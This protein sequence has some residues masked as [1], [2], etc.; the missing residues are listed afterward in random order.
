HLCAGGV[1]PPPAGLVSRA[2]A[3]P[4][5]PVRRG[6]R[7]TG[8]RRQAGVPPRHRDAAARVPRATPAQ[9]GGSLAPRAGPALAAPM[10]ATSY[11]RHPDVLWRRSLEAVLG[12]PPGSSEPVTLAGTG[13]EVWDL[14]ER[15]CSIDELASELAQRHGTDAETVARDVLPVVERLAELRL[16]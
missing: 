15:P 2:G 3:W 16:L 8:H 6:T 9:L 5:D 10:T 7:R 4:H 14:L 12:L 13:P 1:R 11:R